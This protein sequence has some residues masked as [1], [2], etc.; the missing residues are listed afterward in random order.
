M[1]IITKIKQQGGFIQ[2]FQ[3]AELIEHSR[4]QMV[5]VRCQGG[6]FM[7]P[8][9]DVQHFIDIIEKDGSDHLRD[10]SLPAGS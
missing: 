3:M 6:R 1:N 5:L 9:Q 2:D 4:L 10:V 7:A 8:A